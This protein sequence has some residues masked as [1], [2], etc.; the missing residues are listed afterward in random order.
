MEPDIVSQ[1]I[2]CE[3]VR[4]EQG[5][6]V[7]LVG[8]LPDRVDMGMA[9]PPVEDEHPHPILPSLYVYS[10]TRLPLDRPVK[11]PVTL[12]FSSPSGQV[13]VEQTFD[14]DFVQTSWEEAQ[15]SGNEFVLL[16]SQFSTQPF[17][18]LEAGRFKVVIQYDGSDFFSGAIRFDFSPFEA[19][20]VH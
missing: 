7:S 17:P 5:G 14:E 11:G 3:S 20:K 1:T 2:F 15:A 8:I 19:E 16:I 6:T 13:I 4:N 10:R 18:V 12:K 9:P